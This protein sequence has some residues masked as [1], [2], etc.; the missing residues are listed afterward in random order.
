MS[1]G[2]RNL[3]KSMLALGAGGTAA[4]ALAGEGPAAKVED[5]FGAHA[6]AGGTEDLY[7]EEFVATYGDG[8]AHGYSYH[9]VNCQ[10]NCAWEVWVD[11]NGRITRENQ[12]ASYPAIA[13][14]VPDANPRGCNKG[15]QHSQ[16]VYG[17]DRLMY[18]MKRAGARGEGKWKRITWD[19][20]IAEIATHLYETMRGAGPGGNYV[21]MGSGMLSE[22]RAASVKRLGT[23]LGAV[24]PYIASYVGDMFP[25]ASVV[26]GEGNVGCTYDF[27]YGT[28]VALF[29]GCNPNTSRM[30]DAHWLWE[31]KYRGSKVIV[32]TPEFNGSAIH[33]DLWVPVKAGYDGHLALAVLHRIVEAKLYRPE[34]LKQLT[35]LP[36]L[37]RTDTKELVRLHDVDLADPRFDEASAERFAADDSK[38]HEVFLAWDL[39][40]KRA[41]ALPGCEGSTVETLR[42]HDLSWNIDP[43]LSGRFRLKLRAH[44]GHAAKEVEVVPAFT[45]F[46]KELQAF[47][48]ART[49]ALT[50][51]HPSVVDRLARE[52]AG[53]KVAVVTLGFAIGKHFN[54]LLSQRA[55]ASLTA[56]LGKLG[57]QGGL[58]T[59]NEWNITG[60]DG[61][62]GFSGRYRHRFASGFVSEFM[63]GNGMDDPSFADEDFRRAT[64]ASR[65]DYRKQVAA[66][67]AQSEGDA[68]EKKGKPWWRQTETFLVFA[69]AR[70]RRNKGAYKKAFLEKAKFVAYGDF[71]MSDFATFADVLLPCTTP[72][73]SWDLRTNPGYHRHANI[74]VPPAGLKRIGESK[75]EWEIATLVAEKIQALALARHAQ[76]KDDRDLRIPDSTHTQAGYHPLDTLVA[77]F[78]LGGK[79]RT[80]RDAVEYALEHVDQ[81]KPNDP[82][83][84]VRRGGF[85]VMNDKAGK[86]SPLYP[87]RPYNTFENNLYLHQRFDTVSGR[88]T[89]YVDHPAWIAAGAHVPTAKL[90][91]Q[92]RRFPLLFMTPHARWSIHS[93][94][95]TSPILQRLQR[96]RPYVMLNP[97]T[98]KARG[99][100][101]GDEVRL[102]NDLGEVRAMAKLAAGVPPT[103]VVMEHGW[104]PYQFRGK[105]H[106]NAIIGHTLNL[107][108]VTDG[109]GHLKFG[110]NWDGN[111]H[112]YDATV[113][114]AR[115]GAGKA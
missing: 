111:Q 20:A 108:E 3:L 48:A 8:E 33:A 50:G 100:A 21:H 86:S 25:G 17:A 107:L 28:D 35:D 79:L 56:F 93:T 49:K 41:T 97:A 74:S 5:P 83:T 22:A 10:G 42:L 112:A 99:I 106:Q 18:P 46:T 4:R 9:C 91:I 113:D 64:G 109:W 67:V 29:W 13:K 51:V 87:D 82:K 19:E 37:V 110:T 70:F 60:L 36:L 78:T 90:P 73:E 92:P 68:G 88:L 55:I 44:G 96:G 7:R 95:K 16:I 11:G 84:M 23:L 31:G 43:A 63:L 38:H 104:E 76:T 65:A 115:V 71:R 30:P 39:K 94:Y 6:S 103:A 58:N 24:R 66:L 14:D 52:L 47:S 102:F 101:D 1:I 45:I 54:G 12:S 72:Y 98:A 34:V 61:L 114:V 2:R 80:D 75:S 69:D 62:A 57:P 15:V 85:L 89:F 26:Y 27:F 105:R 77:D 32:V 40:T 53:S 59:E 81:F